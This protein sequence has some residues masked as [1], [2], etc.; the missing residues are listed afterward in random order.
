MHLNV[1]SVNSIL[2]NLDELKAITGNSKAAVNCITESKIDNSA[3]DTEAEISGCYIIWCDRNRN[4]GIVTC[5]FGRTDVLNCDSAM[6]EIE[7]KVSDILLLK[8]K[9][10]SIG[11]IYEPSNNN[12]TE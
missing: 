3:T 4:W 6:G 7:G 10:I 8:T 5:Y 1:N 12:F 11:I 2:R 9:P